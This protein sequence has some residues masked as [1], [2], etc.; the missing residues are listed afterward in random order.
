MI[1]DIASIIAINKTVLVIHFM[2]VFCVSQILREIFIYL[3]IY[4]YI[5]LFNGEMMIPENLI[6]VMS[7]NNA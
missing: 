4:L 2:F 1:I 6:T 5:C 3:F 7:Q